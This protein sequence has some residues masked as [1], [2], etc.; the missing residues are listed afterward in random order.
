MYSGQRLAMAF[1][2]LDGPAVSGDDADSR[3]RLVRAGEA[4][5]DADLAIVLNKAGT[6]IPM[7]T[8]T[9]VERKRAD[10]AAIDAAAAKGDPNAHRRTHPCG[11]AHAI[12]DRR[13]ATR[14]LTRIARRGAFNLGVE[15]RASRVLIVDLDTGRQLNEF[16]LRCG[17]DRPGLTVRSPGQRDRAGNW[18]HRDGGHIWF[19]VPEHIEL[20]TEDGIYTDASG[21]SAIWG[22]HQVLVPP[23]VRAEGAYKLVGAMH[24]LP[25]WLLET[26]T[27][28]VA[29]KK[30]RREESKRR[31][32]TSGPSQIDDWAVETAWSDILTSDG[33]ID[34]G[35]VD[36]SCGCPI[37]TAPGEHASPKSATAHEPG[38]GKYVCER[39]HGPLHV[40]TDNPSDAVAAAIAEYGTRTLTKI[41]VLTHTEGEGRMGR[42]LRDLGISDDRGPTII[43]SPFATW[44]DEGVPPTAEEKTTSSSLP[45]PVQESEESEEDGEDEPVEE[46]FTPEELFERRV[47]REFEHELVRRAALERVAALDARPLRILSFGE[48]LRAPRPE[49]LIDNMLY[50]DSLARIYGPAGGGKSFLAIDLAMSKAI[51]QFWHGVKLTP[52]PVVYVMAEGQRVNGDRAEAWLSYH[53]KSEEDLGDRFYAVPEAVILT[54]TGAAD[55]VKKV[56]EIRPAMVILDTK[57]AMMDGNE[58]KSED[59]A[60]MRRVLD[61]IRGSSDCC[62]VL[63]DHTGYEGTRPRGSSAGTAMMD[64][65]IRVTKDDSETPSLITAEVTRDKAGEAGTTW[66]WRLMPESPA[67]VLEP[68]EAGPRTAQAKPDW[69]A[70]VIVLPDPVESYDGT[71]KKAVKDLARMMMFETV[72]PHDRSQIGRTMAD[73]VRELSGVHSRSS[74]VRAWSQLKDMGYLVSRFAEPTETQ[75]RNGPHVWEGPNGV[76]AV[77]E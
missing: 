25:D 47:R 60:R 73:A 41:Q 27:S 69:M 61:Q 23:S 71:G 64:S 55:F 44:E 7:C 68:T 67:A 32:A 51:G 17:K 3:K 70:A 46:T 5:V 45:E 4:M 20:P 49:P 31:R 36:G 2:A 10:Q 59:N 12:T 63:I 30:A 21:W 40:W 43:S 19:E 15:P 42:T 54:E 52:E 28:A 62:V 11:L 29:A 1:G 77:S 8:L 66:A 13:T 48:F 38:C 22:E 65:E 57:N 33:W 35:L 50:R 58:D 6:K 75:D 56:Q 16:A 26:I 53:K 76:T 14:V 37:W 24:P 39:G 9:A 72:R 34:T 74:V 18:A